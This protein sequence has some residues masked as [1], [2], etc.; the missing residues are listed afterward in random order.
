MSTWKYWIIQDE[1]KQELTKFGIRII[2]R[3]AVDFLI[4]MAYNDGLPLEDFISKYENLIKKTFEYAISQRRKTIMEEDLIITMNQWFPNLLKAPKFEPK[5]LMEV[6]KKGTHAK[7]SIRLE[8][9]ENLDLVEYRK[10]LENYLTE[11]APLNHVLKIIAL[12]FNENEI[13]YFYEQLLN[14]LTSC[15]S[16]HFRE[17]A[18]KIFFGRKYNE[19]RFSRFNMDHFFSTLPSPQYINNIFTL[20]LRD[21][22]WDPGNYIRYIRNIL[23]FAGTKEHMIKFKSWFK[24]LSSN[25]DEDA[26]EKLNEWVFIYEF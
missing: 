13:E 6:I 17:D 11:V 26:F 16:F 21:S 5:V 15:E 22:I 9:L 10:H 19:V 20:N 25:M 12:I 23:E 4:M 18:L 1:L 2:A 3:D 24:G 8:E 14:F 7:L